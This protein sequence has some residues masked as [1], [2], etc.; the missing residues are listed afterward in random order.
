MVNATSRPLYPQERDSVP[1]VQQAGWVPGPVW[2][3]AAN[4]APTGIRSPGR[5]DRNKS[6]YRL[7]CPGGESETG[8][9]FTQNTSLFLVS[10]VP[11]MLQTHRLLNTALTKMKSRRSVLTFKESKVL[12]D[13]EGGERHLHKG[14]SARD[15]KDER[16]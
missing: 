7:S 6:L 1:I 8:T 4:L 16:C 11:P 14:A 10:I 12:S 5:P 15:T 9:G 13:I 3:G 2:T